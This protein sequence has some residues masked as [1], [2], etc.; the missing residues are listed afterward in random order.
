[1]EECAA[2]FRGPHGRG[3]DDRTALAGLHEELA[4]VT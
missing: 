1:M 3:S 2:W 4:G